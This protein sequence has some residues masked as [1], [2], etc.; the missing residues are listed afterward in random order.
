MNHLKKFGVV[1]MSI[2]VLLWVL[3]P[4]SWAN[5]CNSKMVITM[6]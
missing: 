6:M 2:T 1:A 5:R 4:R 3:S